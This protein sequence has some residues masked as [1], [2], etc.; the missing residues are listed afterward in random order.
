MKNYY[1]IS[2][3]V[4]CGYQNSVY[5]QYF[6]I[7]F[8]ST[9]S[10]LDGSIKFRFQSKNLKSFQLISTKHKKNNKTRQ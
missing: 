7:H 6:L 1:D 4:Y 3:I 5:I 10:Q 8:K 2:D 9:E